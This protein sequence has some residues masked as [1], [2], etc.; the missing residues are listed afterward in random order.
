MADGQTIGK[1]ALA[2][3][4]QSSMICYE[5]LTRNRCKL[6]PPELRAIARWKAGD[7]FVMLDPLTAW[8]DDLPILAGRL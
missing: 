4:T 2:A 7:D 1:P 6:V 5:Q 8:D 3:A